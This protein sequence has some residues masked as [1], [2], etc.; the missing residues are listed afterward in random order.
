MEQS[1]LENIVAILDEEY[2]FNIKKSSFIS[3]LCHNTKAEYL[4]VLACEAGQKATETVA[5]LGGAEIWNKIGLIGGIFSGLGYALYHTKKHDIND[6]KP[7]IK[8]TITFV[9]SAETGCV[10]AATTIEYLVTNLSQV[11]IPYSSENLMLTAFGLPIAFA[12]GLPIMTGFTYFNSREVGKFIAQDKSLNQLKADIINQDNSELLDFS[13]KRNKIRILG[14][15]NYVD[16]VRKRLP[17]K[18]IKEFNPDKYSLFT[19]RSPIA[20]VNRASADKLLSLISSTYST[21]NYPIKKIQSM[22]DNDHTD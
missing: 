18:Y 2:S 9:A 6:Q 8:D 3:K 17:K 13:E 21:H 19:I 5:F 20:R 22:Y 14:K 11:N 12:I 7:S 4:C 10:I 16:I 15:Q 1:Q